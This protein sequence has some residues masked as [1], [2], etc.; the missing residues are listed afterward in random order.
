VVEV[1]GLTLPQVP[2]LEEL[3]VAVRVELLRVELRVLQT[4]AVVGVAVVILLGL[5]AVQA[6][7]ALSLFA[8]QLNTLMQLHIHQP[9][10]QQQMGIRF[11]PSLP[12][13]QS[14]SKEHT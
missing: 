5:L 7:L 3:A 9:L 10:K 14:P 11:I 12:L 1:L 8:I 13:E 2:H 6:A 4:Q